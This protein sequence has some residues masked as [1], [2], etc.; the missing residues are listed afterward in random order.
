VFV[1]GFIGSPAMNFFDVTLVQEDGALYVDTG[2]F[3]LLV[4][5]DRKRVYQNYIGKEAVLGI[6]PEHIH[7]ASFSPPGIVASPL[8]GSVEVV[9]LLGHELHMYINTGTYSFVATVDTRLK[10]D[11][12]DKVDLVVDMSRMHLFDKDTE[13]AIR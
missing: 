6:R 10:A 1:A 5:D 3:R 11:M 9:E 12:G 4:P 8:K 13:W 2:D 7:A